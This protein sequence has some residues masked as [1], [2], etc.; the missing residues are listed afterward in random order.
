VLLKEEEGEEKYEEN[1]TDFEGAY[2]G[3]SLVDSGNWRCH[4]P[5]ELT[6]QISCVSV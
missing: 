4:T 1:K 5:K 6:Q 3:K 2:L